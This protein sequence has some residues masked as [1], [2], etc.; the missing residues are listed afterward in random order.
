M[1][2]NKMV[3]VEDSVSLWLRVVLVLDLGDGVGDFDI[4]GGER[5]LLCFIFSS[6]VIL[7]YYLL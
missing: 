7:I 4:L 3:I 1:H 6:L 2:L 5:P